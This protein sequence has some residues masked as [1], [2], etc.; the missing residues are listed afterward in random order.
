MLV[1][2]EKWEKELE[3]WIEWISE[4]LRD[5]GVASITGGITLSILDYKYW[6]FIIFGLLSLRTSVSLKFGKD[7]KISKQQ[8]EKKIKK[9]KRVLLVEVLFFLAMGVILFFTNFNVFIFFLL[10]LAVWLWL[11]LQVV[12]KK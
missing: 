6:L 5:L 2:N 9:I 11:F 12:G 8:I 7:V 3:E 10:F 1:M 4:F